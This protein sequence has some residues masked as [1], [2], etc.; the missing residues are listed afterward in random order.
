MRSEEFPQK[1][2]KCG[3]PQPKP[4]WLAKSY[5]ATDP[6]PPE[7]GVRSRSRICGYHLPVLGIDS[8]GSFGSSVPFWIS[9]TEISSGERTKAMCPS[10]GGRLIVYAHVHEM[11][12]ERVDVVDAHR[13]GDR[14]C[15][16]R[17]R[18]RGPS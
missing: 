14:N 1:L 17:C 11:L 2:I 5:R 12:A 7:N 16:R 8:H 4:R 10:R 15:G 9:S 13:R 3:E 18:P 6:A